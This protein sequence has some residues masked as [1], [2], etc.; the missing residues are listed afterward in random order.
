MSSGVVRLNPRKK[1][2]SFD[3]DEHFTKV[4]VSG[5]QKTGAGEN[6]VALV[7]ND[8]ENEGTMESN[9]SH[10]LGVADSETSSSDSSSV[11]ENETPIWLSQVNNESI[12]TKPIIRLEAWSPVEEEASENS[13]IDDY[14]TTGSSSSISY[15]PD[16]ESTASQGSV[17]ETE[18]SDLDMDIVMCETLVPPVVKLL[19]ESCDWIEENSDLI[20][21]FSSKPSVL[22][23][24]QKGKT[25]GSDWDKDHEIYGSCFPPVVELLGDSRA[26]L[27][28]KN[29]LLYGLSPEPSLLHETEKCLPKISCDQKKADFHSKLIKEARVMS[30]DFHPRSKPPVRIDTGTTITS[31]HKSS[32]QKAAFLSA[33]RTARENKQITP[34]ASNTRATKTNGTPVIEED[35][36]IIQEIKAKK[37]VEE[38]SSPCPQNVVAESEIAKSNLPAG[39]EVVLHNVEKDQPVPQAQESRTENQQGET[40]Q[41]S[42]QDESQYRQSL[43][44]I[45]LTV[46]DDVQ[47][48]KRGQDPPGKS[49]HT[50]ESI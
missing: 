38:E 3:L 8:D 15:A 14:D 47:S 40:E 44:I 24:R 18:E 20:H 33:T 25:K 29:D 19:D 4:T 6:I 21:G 28:E 7:C 23:G 37:T 43:D 22:H 35:C 1:E 16:S 26:W 27:E 45:D 32:L 2:V 42:H 48:T 13:I 12:V 39:Y 34:K 36:P 46:C 5:G 9:S 49:A 50:K 10:D 41:T 11:G 31:P 17:F 30:K